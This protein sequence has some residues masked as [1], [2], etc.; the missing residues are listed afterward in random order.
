MTASYLARRL[1]VMLFVLWA[2]A[3]IN[4]VIP[5]LSPA[6]PIRE[7]LIQAASQGGQQAGN[8]EEV[9]KSYEARFGLDQPLWLQYFR[10]LGD[11]ARLDLGVSITRFPTRV[12]DMVLIALPW[13]IVLIAVS[14]MLAFALGT[15]VGA[16]L[17]LPAGPRFLHYLAPP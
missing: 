13:T 3:T 10:Y 7:R 16:L 15:L 5:R 4:F 14:T 6:N 12:S 2:A 1:G 17:A 11:L 8:I 9:V